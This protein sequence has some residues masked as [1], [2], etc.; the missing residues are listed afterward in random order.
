MKVIMIY[1]SANDQPFLQGGRDYLDAEG[2]NYEEV[3]LSAHRDL[4]E[5]MEFLL[6]ERLEEMLAQSDSHNWP[7]HPALQQ[8]FKE[9]A[10]ER[11]LE[12]DYTEVADQL[13]TAIKT[14]GEILR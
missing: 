12:I 11:P 7:I 2:V 5:L 13:K 4:P 14:A 10:I 9:Y 6:S 3:V 1:G 8:R